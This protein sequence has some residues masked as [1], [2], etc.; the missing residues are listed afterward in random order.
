MGRKEAAENDLATLKKLNSHLA[1][2][3]ETYIKT[4]KE[5]EDQY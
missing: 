2:E 1:A 3:L 5:D 4:G